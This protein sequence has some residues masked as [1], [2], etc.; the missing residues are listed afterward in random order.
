MVVV[1]D[2]STTTAGLIDNAIVHRASLIDIHASASQHFVERTIGVAIGAIGGGASF[3]KLN[4]DDSGATEVKAFVGNNVNIGQDGGDSVGGLDVTAE[5]TIV[6]TG[7]AF[8][9][10]G[11]LVAASVNFAFVDVTGEV[12]ASVGDG[13][14][15]ANVKLTGTGDVDVNAES[16]ADV[17]SK[18]IGA[19]VGALAGGLSKTEVN[20]SP[21]VRARVVKGNIRARNL[22]VS[23]KA[24]V[25]APDDYGAAATSFTT[26]FGGAAIGGAFASATNSPT[27][28]A[29]VASDEVIANSGSVAI[30]A[31]GNNKARAKSAGA[32]GGIVGIG[33]TEAEAHADGSVSAHLDGQIVGDDNAPGAVNL[34]IPP[35]RPTRPRVGDRGD[36]RAARRWHQ[37]GYG[38]RESDGGWLYSSSGTVAVSGNIDVDATARSEADSVVKGVGVGGVELGG[39]QSTTTVHPDVNSYIVASDVRAGGDVSVVATAEPIDGDVPDYQCPVDESG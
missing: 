4:V 18:V 9:L 12:V 30:T 17:N 15:G 13:G 8:G 29:A 34:D 16:T 37:Y 19:A 38:N 2:S 14:T 1:N 27:V 26:A 20:L 7:T 35:C 5:S 10:A 28:E 32:N 31:Q 22:D 33:L 23:A 11:G 39:T 3:T 36:R 6:A 25:G 24:N 21:E